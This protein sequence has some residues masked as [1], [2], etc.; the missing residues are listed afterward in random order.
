MKEKRTRKTGY[1]KPRTLEVQMRFNHDVSCSMIE[2]DRLRKPPMTMPSPRH[3]SRWCSGCCR[4]CG[5]HMECVTN[6]HAEKHGYKNANEMIKAGQ[7]IF[8]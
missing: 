3:T 1:H 5:E 7:I 2:R 8:D 6:L 4:I